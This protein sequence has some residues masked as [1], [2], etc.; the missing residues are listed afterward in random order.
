MRVSQEVEN[1]LV[2]NY[3]E[4]EIQVLT[5]FDTGNEDTI[6]DI[7]T[8]QL[9][10]KVFHHNYGQQKKSSGTILSIAEISNKDL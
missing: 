8:M 3:N 2:D 5:E 10:N 7:A 9:K 4:N 6:A 1:A